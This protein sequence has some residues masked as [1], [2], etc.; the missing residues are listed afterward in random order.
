MAVGE[1]LRIQ[2]Q[3]FYHNGIFKLMSSLDKRVNV[4]GDYAEKQWYLSRL[5]ELHVT[6][7]NVSHVIFMLYMNYMYI[8]S[9]FTRNVL[10]LHC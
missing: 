6:L 1:W 8:I 5:N 7:L 9:C 2:E 4:L 10:F 3:R